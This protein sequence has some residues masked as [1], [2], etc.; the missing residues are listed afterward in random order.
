MPIARLGLAIQWDLR[1][2]NLLISMK[3]V[4]SPG[5]TQDDDRLMRA[6]AFLLSEPTWPISGAVADLTEKDLSTHSRRE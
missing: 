6:I 3:A 2:P 1:A 5:I 4:A